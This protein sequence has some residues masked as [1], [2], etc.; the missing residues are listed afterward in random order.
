MMT[1]CAGKHTVQLVT[2]TGLSVPDRPVTFPGQS[3]SFHVWVPELGKFVT[4]R[5]GSETDKP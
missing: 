3:G 2:L 1:D 5:P 4:D